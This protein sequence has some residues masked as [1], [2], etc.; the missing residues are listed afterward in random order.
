[1]ATPPLANVCRTVEVD[2]EPRRSPGASDHTV[3]WTGDMNVAPEPID[4]YHPDRRVNEV[5]FHI[6]ARKAW[7]DASAWGFVDVFRKLHPDRVQYT[8][9]D[10]FRNAFG[11]NFGWRIDHIMATPPLANVCRTVEVDLEPRRSPGASD[12]TV[13]WAEFDWPDANP[14]GA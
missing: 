7:A 2:L 10:Y 12:H 13:I 1:M 6:D 11:N 4:V 3:I 8:Y 9:W 5:D 14:Q